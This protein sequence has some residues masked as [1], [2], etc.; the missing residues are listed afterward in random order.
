MGMIFRRKFLFASVGAGIGGGIAI[1]KCA[2][3]FNRIQAR[4]HRVAASLNNPKNEDFKTKIDHLREN[5]F[6]K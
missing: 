4:E 2:D 1:N 3:E 6:K 5:Y